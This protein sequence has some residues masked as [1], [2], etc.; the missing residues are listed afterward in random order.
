MEEMVDIK[1]LTEAQLQ[2]LMER[3]L[4]G[5]TTLQ[6]VK[7]LTDEQMEALYGV[8]YNYY[9]IGKYVDAS[10]LF[11]WL[12][13]CNPFTGKYWLGLGASLQLARDFERALYA[14]GMAAVTGEPK[15]PTPHLHAAECYLAQGVME[16]ARKA[17]KMAAD[18]GENRTECGKVYKKAKALLSILEEKKNG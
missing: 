11:T 7:G 1:E 17:L 14:Y 12:T 2:D 15:D 18:F 5:E 16:D 10:Q 3:L 6:E 9:M 8:A 13:L 4:S